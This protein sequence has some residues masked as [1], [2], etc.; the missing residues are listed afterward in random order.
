MADIIWGI[1]KEVIDGD[2][3]RLN[4]THI[5]NLNKDKYSAM[6]K[7]RIAGYNAPELSTPGGQKAKQDLFQKIN[8]KEVKCIIQARDSYIRIIANVIVV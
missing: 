7:I 2:T 1:V 6:E 8:G 3:F 5:S 4:V